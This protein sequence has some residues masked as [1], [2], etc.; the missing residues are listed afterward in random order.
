M[1]R[2]MNQLGIAIVRDRPPTGWVDRLIFDRRHKL[3]LWVS[4]SPAIPL[5]VLL[6]ALIPSFAKWLTGFWS[7]LMQLVLIGLSV[8]ALVHGLQIDSPGRWSSWLDPGINSL[9][10]WFSE[11]LPFCLWLLLL[12]ALVHGGS[13]LG[14]EIRAYF[15][16]GL[17]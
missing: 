1:D 9:G 15:L 14:Q 13:M 16:K 6:S 2:I 5:F 7:P 3:R 10:D 4:L 12:T 11:R 17:S 8:D